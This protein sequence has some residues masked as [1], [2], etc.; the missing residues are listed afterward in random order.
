MF[1]VM[2]VCLKVKLRCQKGIPPSLRGRAW[3][4]LSGGKVK[5]EQNLGRFQVRSDDG[6]KSGSCDH[7]I[8]GSV[9]LLNSPEQTD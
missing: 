3:L 8:K 2:S 9:I 1:T 6:L 4:Y 7:L 5:R